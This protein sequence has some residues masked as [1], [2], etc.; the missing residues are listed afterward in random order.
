MSKYHNLISIYV[1]FGTE[2]SG[3]GKWQPVILDEFSLSQSQSQ[4]SLELISQ[5][6]P[7]RLLQQIPPDPL[8][9]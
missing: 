1:P 2:R 8:L 5:G 7:G 9:Q 4:G 3:D 6:S